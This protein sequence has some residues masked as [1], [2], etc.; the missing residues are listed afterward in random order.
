MNS[1]DIITRALRRLG[2]VASGQKA[3]DTEIDDALDT[4]KGI[5]F[6]LISE[7]TLGVLSDETAG[8]GGYDAAAA[9][10]ILLDNPNTEAVN[11]P[12]RAKNGSAVIVADIFENTST[13][14]IFDGDLAKWLS[15]EAMTRTSPAPF[16]KRD[17]LGLACY[18]ALELGDE[19]GIQ[20]SESISFNAAR[21]HSSLTMGAS[22]ET[23]T[24]ARPTDYF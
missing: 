14:Y 12:D 2:V 1:I 3:T 24:V 15:I 17:P 18:L 23:E 8:A 5:Y 6:R 7:G 11:L 10:R 20:P 16:A 4:L 22:R 21:F 9:S 19:Y 13:T